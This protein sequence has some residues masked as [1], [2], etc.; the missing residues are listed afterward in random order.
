MKYKYY[1][2][3]DN[4]AM[5]LLGSARGK[6]EVSLIYYLWLKIIGFDVFKEKED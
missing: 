5:C 1:V 2:K 6:T 4:K 3:S